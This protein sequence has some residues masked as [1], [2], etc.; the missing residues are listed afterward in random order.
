MEKVGT[1]GLRATSKNRCGAA[2]KWA[3]KVRL[4][5]TPLGDS[6]NGQPL[7]VLGDQPHTMQKS[8]TSGVQR[9]KPTESEG[10]PTCPSNRQLSAGDT[11]EEGRLRGSKRAG[12]LAMSGSLG[13]AFVWRLS[14]K[15]TW[16]PI[17]PRRSSQI[18]SEQSAGLWMSS[19]R[20]DS[21]Q[22]GLFLLGE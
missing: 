7:S 3:R 19:L 12:N 6:G 9:V 14:V 21:P 1:H 13:R 5:E 18:F 20:R 16:R 17:S 2:K 22:A 11:P 10:L 4:A 8:G 15:T